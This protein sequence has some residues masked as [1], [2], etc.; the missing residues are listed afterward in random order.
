[1]PTAPVSD[2]AYNLD[3]TTHRVIGHTGGGKG[4]GGHSP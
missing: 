1:V 3:P 4:A 2:Q